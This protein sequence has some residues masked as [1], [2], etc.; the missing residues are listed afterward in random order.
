MDN[1]SIN[2]LSKF[3]ISKFNIS[4]SIYHKKYIYIL[5]NKLIQLFF[6]KIFNEN[7][8]SIFIKFIIKLGK[9]VYAFYILED[10]V[11]IINGNNLIFNKI[12]EDIC[13]FIKN[14]NI[15]IQN[16]QVTNILF[17]IINNIEL[18][19]K[20]EVDIINILL[21]IYFLKY[22]KTLFE[23]L[24]KSTLFHFEKI[25]NKSSIL[26][27]NDLNINHSLFS[28]NI[29]INFLNQLIQKEYKK[30]YQDKYKLYSGFIFNKQLGSLK[31][32]N[33]VEFGSAKSISIIFSF[34]FSKITN[35]RINLL[36]LSNEDS[37]NQYFSIF[38]END[39][40]YFSISQP[41]KEQFI[42][43]KGNELIIK[44][45]ITY[46]II[47]TISKGDPNKILIIIN[48]K[49]YDYTSKYGKSFDYLFNYYNSEL[50]ICKNN[51]IFNGIIG[52][53]LLFNC[54][55]PKKIID[56]I[57][58]F[59]GDY[60]NILLCNENNEYNI[61]N[62]IKSHLNDFETLNEFKLLEYL[63]AIIS[64]KSFLIKG[65]SYSSYKENFYD[66]TIF[67]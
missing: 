35:K 57:L 16:H 25:G 40:L 34:Y 48:G 13:S 26:K 52:T 10:I 5:Q 27:K 50:N 42:F 51:N 61:R 15:F 66:I 18:N 37:E 2:Y 11:K 41:K 6:S 59:K 28:L 44:E 49:E 54:A 32:K 58:S 21:K 30:L 9:I 4:K 17:F 62:D 22:D 64:P 45:K 31:L 19:E 47:I 23:N 55:F 14:E 60:E 65:E 36:E 7:D 53:V 12:L 8:I 56:I 3:N 46:L 24:I 38:T 67:M 1:N 20:N 29:Q 33:I 43:P 63:K 39:S